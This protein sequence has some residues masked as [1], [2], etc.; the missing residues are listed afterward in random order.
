MQPLTHLGIQCYVHLDKDRHNYIQNN[1]CFKTSDGKAGLFDMF[2]FLFVHFNEGWMRDI[3]RITVSYQED[4]IRI[5]EVS[6]IFNKKLEQSLYRIEGNAIEAFQY[7]CV[8]DLK[9][10]LKY[11]GYEFC[12]VG[13]VRPEGYFE[14]TRQVGFEL[15]STLHKK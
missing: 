15:M 14:T 11:V 1:S 4:P 8:T 3:K 2:Y 7:V 13:L 12:I 5:K 6:D 9:P 10:N